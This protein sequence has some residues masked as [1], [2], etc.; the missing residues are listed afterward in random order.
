MDF[1]VGAS[2]RSTTAALLAVCGTAVVPVALSVPRIRYM[3]LSCVTS[4]SHLL[5]IGLL[6]LGLGLLGSGLGLGLGL[7]GLG[8]G[9]L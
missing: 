1:K 9:L 6:G 3:Y 8:L 4:V 5:L 7:L 2:I